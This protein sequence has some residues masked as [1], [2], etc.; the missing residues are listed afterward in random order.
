MESIVI[1]FALHWIVYPCLSVSL[2]QCHCWDLQVCNSNWAHNNTVASHFRKAVITYWHYCLFFFFWC[3]IINFMPPAVSIC[4]TAVL[5][6]WAFHLSWTCHRTVISNSNMHSNLNAC[7]VH[8]G[9]TD[10][11]IIVCT[12]WLQRRTAQVPHHVSTRGWA[13]PVAFIS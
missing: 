3:C 1:H 13:L 8:K 5:N 11:L 7:T 4:Y 10:V 6:C 9:K 12:C 2:C